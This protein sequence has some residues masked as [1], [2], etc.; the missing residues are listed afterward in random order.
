MGSLSRAIR[1]LSR[2][3]AGDLAL[4]TEAWWRFA[5]VDLTIRTRDYRHWRH[6]LQDETHEESAELPAV[7]QDVVR[8]SEI[9]ARHHWAPMNC[10]R[11]S[12]VQRQLLARRQVPS[13]LHI[14]VRLADGKRLEAHAWLSS[15]GQLLNDTPA[16]VATYQPFEPGKSG[17]PP[18]FR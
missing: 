11:R 13:T 1:G 16:N 9:A 3:S 14:G 15:R 8:L 2:L 4:L 6:W 10:L 17:V 5:I 12:L 7:V 18:D